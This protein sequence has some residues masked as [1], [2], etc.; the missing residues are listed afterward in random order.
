VVKELL[1]VRTVN[2]VKPKCKDCKLWR[3]NCTFNIK[4]L[5][6]HIPQEQREKWI[7][8]WYTKAQYDETCDEYKSLEYFVDK[9]K[10]DIE[11]RDLPYE[12]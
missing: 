5:P 10:I 2:A 1:K 8:I 11:F 7:E 6:P 9:H 3:K 12:R 4:F